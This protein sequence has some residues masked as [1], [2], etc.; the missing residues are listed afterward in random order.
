MMWKAV[1]KRFAI[2]MATPAL[3]L[4][5]GACEE[6]PSA[7]GEVMS[8]RVTVENVSMPRAFTSSG[9]FAT[10]VG[11]DEPGP[12][13][14]GGAYEVE[15]F[16]SPGDRL[17]F[18]TMFVP[19]NDFFYAP[20]EAGIALFDDDGNPISG[21]V[22]MQVELWDAGTEINQEPGLGPDQVQRQPGPDT[23]D[24]DPV[25]T[26]RMAPDDFDN[27]PAVTDVIRAMIE[28]QGE[29]RFTLRIENVS[30]KQT[31]ATSD[32]AMQAVPL[33]PGVYVIHSEP[34]PL[35][36]VDEAAGEGLERVAEDG[37]PEAFVG[38]LEAE[39]GYASPI[40][41]GVLAVVVGDGSGANPLFTPDEP[42]RG[43]GLEGL[44]EDGD[45]GPLGMVLADD[46][47]LA[48]AGIF[49]TPSGAGEPGPAGPG[50][51][52]EFEVQG[53]DEN[54]LYFATMLVQTNDLFFA[55]GAGIP[56]FDTAG[57]PMSGDVTEYVELWDA[58]TEANQNPG[59]GPDQ[60]PRQAGPDTG[61]ED[62]DTDVRMV[63][64]SFSY[65]PVEELIRVTITP[66]GG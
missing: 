26:V 61:E 28:H 54:T 50:A 15:L 60:A 1:T 29:D 48:D 58:G 2:C 59:T 14:P 49:D 25:A 56:L 63:D 21:D 30:S 19:S 22:T 64:D 4:I 23:G 12:I 10:P 65:P 20:D 9:A 7:P 18:A 55:P 43:D 16:A 42:D 17:S 40:A 11:A 35:F 34:G 36:T 53:S 31:L 46:P 37:E 8:F 45:A 5:A 62:P 32:M 38:E 41:P 39:T 57:A 3:A 27:L 52:Y 13:G 44:A 6:D 66:N 47:D 33:S 24:E 51:S